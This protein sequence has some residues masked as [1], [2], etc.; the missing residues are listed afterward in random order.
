MKNRHLVA[1]VSTLFVVPN[2]ALAAGMSPLFMALVWMGCAG[3]I[4]L[5]WSRRGAPEGAF[6]D[7]AVDWRLL[8]TACAA[9][10]LL[11]LLGGSLHL[12]YTQDDWLMRDAVLSD[13]SGRSFP[14]VYHREGVDYLLRAPLGM[15]LLPGL[16]G[17]G[18][19]DFAAHVALL[20]QNTF[21]V[22]AAAYVF[23]SLAPARRGLF[24]ALFFVFSGL[25][26]VA[27]L[28][29]IAAG[30]ADSLWPP[31]DIEWWTPYFQ[32]SSVVTQLF[33]APNHAA[34]GWWLA[35]LALLTARREFD[36]ARLGVM[37]A[38]MA[39]WSPLA[40]VAAP[41]FLIYFAA[42]DRLR[43][44]ATLRLWL[45]VGVAALF[46]PVAMYLTIASGTVISTWL[47]QAP[48]FWP[49]YVMFLTLAIPQA[50][51]V[52]KCRAQIDDAFK[53]L[54]VVA[55]GLLFLFPFYAFGPGNDLAMRGSI[56]SLAILAFAFNGLLTRFDWAGKR[57]LG[58]LAC[59]LV[60]LGAATPL[61]E[62]ARGLY[63]PRFAIGQCDL[64]TAALEM[65]PSG[66]PDNYVAP[67]ADFPAW[68]LARAATDPIPVLEQRAP[69]WPDHPLP[70][71]IHTP[72]TPR[73]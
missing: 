8:S 9:T 23:A 47:F 19:G 50:Y 4:A 7:G 38:A 34:P 69:C 26:V 10:L 37:T 67:L 27:Q 70:K 64:L 42:R 22:G 30:G 3:A 41:A 1:G 49:T 45:G 24:L 72:P 54:V 11:S 40:I 73:K 55:V 51:V 58:L 32:Y 56:P 62:V 13:L 14:V 43:D 12:L 59:V 2:A 39:L 35:A 17:R 53:G 18:A 16:V 28:K 48:G 29:M 21:V 31:R 60:A 15:Y 44:L 20:V 61:S 66:N 5:T 36:I 63:Y 33:W 25:D 52:Y 71:E 65:D 68:M 6:V 57:A 46:A